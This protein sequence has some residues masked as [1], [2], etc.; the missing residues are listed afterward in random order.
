MNSERRSRLQPAAGALFWDGGSRFE[1]VSR[2]LSA[3][4]ALRVCAS[5]MLAGVLVRRDTFLGQPNLE[6]L[7]EDKIYLMHGSIFLFAS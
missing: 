3:A 5:W 2:A 4:A 7:T 1:T 6:P